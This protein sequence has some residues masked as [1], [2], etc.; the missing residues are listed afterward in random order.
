M[1]FEHYLF[2][3]GPNDTR[4]AAKLLT[5]PQDLRELKIAG[6]EDWFA[7]DLP[8]QGRVSVTIR[9]R[10]ADG[11]LDLQLVDATGRVVGSSEGT[12]DAESASFTATAAGRVY[13]RA[14]GYRNAR[15]PYT[16][17]LR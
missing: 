15:G 1:R 3:Q 13:V 10:H 14:F 7:V 2:G 8:A 17:E 16:L 5:I 9:F 6:N 11:D 12:S 4:A